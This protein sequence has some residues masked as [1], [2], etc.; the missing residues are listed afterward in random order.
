MSLYHLT[1]KTYYS[2]C[3]TLTFPKRDLDIQDGKVFLV[4]VDDIPIPKNLDQDS[5]SLTHIVPRF[6]SDKKKLYFGTLL[7]AAFLIPFILIFMNGF[8]FQKNSGFFLS[9]FTPFHAQ[10]QRKLCCS[11][12]L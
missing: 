8:T 10:T 7:S 1:T 12:S 9:I 5:I 3:L 4:D 11:I 2:K 6:I